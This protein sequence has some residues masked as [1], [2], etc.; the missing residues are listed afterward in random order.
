MVG[1][2]STYDANPYAPKF[3]RYNIADQKWENKTNPTNIYKFR[4]YAQARVSNNILYL[5][6]GENSDRSGNEVSIWAVSLLDPDFAWYEVQVANDVNGILSRNS[7]GITRVG[8]ELYMFGG[9]MNGEVRNDFVKFNLSS[10][11]LSFM[12]FPTFLSPSQRQYHSFTLV[13]GYLYLFGGDREGTKL[14]DLWRWDIVEKQW[15]EVTPGGTIPDPRSH[16]ACSSYGDVM[17]VFGGVGEFGYLNDV[18][19]YNS[20]TNVWYQIESASQIIPSIR[21]GACLDIKDSEIAIYGGKTRSGLSDE[22]WILDLGSRLFT[23]VDSDNSNGPGPLYLSS[24]RF[25]SDHPHIFYVT[26]GIT[27][28]EAPSNGFY[29]FNLTKSKWTKIYQG[30]TNSLYDRADIKAFKIRNRYL[31]IGGDIYNTP[32]YSLTYFNTSSKEFVNFAELPEYIYAAGQTYF[33]S[34]YYTHGGGKTIGNN[35]RRTIPTGVS[36]QINLLSTCEDSSNCGWKCSPGSYLS[37]NSCVSCPAGTYQPYFETT[38]C[39]KCPP[40]TYYSGTAAVTIIQCYPCSEGTYNSDFGMGYCINCPANTYW[41]AG[42]TGYAYIV[43]TFSDSSIQPN[44]FKEGDSTANN[45]SSYVS[46]AI[47]IFGI[48]II[49]ILIIIARNKDILVKIDLYS[50]KHNYLLNVPMVLTKTKVGG[51]FS[52]I[53]MIL[54]IIVIASTLINFVE[55]NTTETKTL[56]PLVVMDEK[57]S[58]YKTDLNVTLTIINYGGPCTDE[59]KCADTIGFTYEYFSGIWDDPKCKSNG[60][61]CEVFLSCIDCVIDPGAYLLYEFTNRS[62]FAS[63]FTTNVTS[64]SSVPDS[65]SSYKTSLLPTSQK[66]FRGEQYSSMFFDLTP[67]YYQNMDSG[68]D[69]TGYHISKSKDS[70]KGTEY[71]TSELAMSYNLYLKIL[72]NR[73]SNCLITTRSSKQTVLILISGLLGSIF[74]V[75]GAIGGAMSFTEGQLNKMKERKDGIRFRGNIAYGS[76]MIKSSINA[77]TPLRK[78]LEDDPAYNKGINDD[79]LCEL[80]L[81]NFKRQSLTDGKVLHQ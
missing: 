56:V 26:N 67:S 9:D 53:F 80:D 77:S 12:Y 24:C 51:F 70:E 33:G 78:T 5:F 22:L 36:L 32:S 35:L 45:H 2:V 60:R 59:E 15:Q 50:A 65:A 75:M 19:L 8:T 73:N 64:N 68:L 40:G 11:P 54:A 25:S 37:E 31:Y 48:L 43:P 38:E 23:L 14:N 7:Y 66:V 27:T 57:V 34:S 30:P 52:I 16:H 13:G 6:P 18:F 1:G 58:V 20:L 39:N 61:D 62:S 4:N 41:P 81:C 49:I 10:N 63:G 28:T 74:G 46:I 17:A 29:S 3:F 69:L 71:L 72:F 79:D 44:L 42:S 21:S 76:D 47:G 55:N